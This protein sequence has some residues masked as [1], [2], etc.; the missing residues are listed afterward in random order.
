MTASS[1][2]AY[3]GNDKPTVPAENFM[4]T[5]AANIDNTRLSAD[6]FREFVRNSLPAVVY[7]RD[8]LPGNGRRPEHTPT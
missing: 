7:P 5:L 2:I 4:A 3:P 8:T 1:T 6:D